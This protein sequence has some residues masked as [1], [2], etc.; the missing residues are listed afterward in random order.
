MAKQPE[1]KSCGNC[2]W[3][4]PRERT[5]TGRPR[6]KSGKCCYVIDLPVLPDCV[7]PVALP[8]RSVWFEDG[9]LCPCHERKEAADE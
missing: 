1:P 2:R 8:R 7:V 6:K 3:W 4:E 9:K 5:P